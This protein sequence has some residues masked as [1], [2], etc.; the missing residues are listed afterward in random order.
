MF[1]FFSSRRR[2]TRFDCDWSSDVCSSDLPSRDPIQPDQMR[3]FL[4]KRKLL[5]MVQGLRLYGKATA[6]D[7]HPKAR[8][9]LPLHFYICTGQMTKL[10]RPNGCFSSQD[11]TTRRKTTG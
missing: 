6:P 4:R 3:K 10:H 8:Q 11:Y 2:H 1:F 9:I 7:T 5:E